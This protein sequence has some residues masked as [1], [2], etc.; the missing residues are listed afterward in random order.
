M[1]YHFFLPLHWH[2]GDVLE[3]R[4]E[5]T[6]KYVVLLTRLLKTYLDVATFDRKGNQYWEGSLV[7]D[8]ARIIDVKKLDG[9]GMSR[10]VRVL[11]DYL[12]VD[13]FALVLERFGR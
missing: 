13:Q 6:E 9:R 3:G 5:S 2:R 7:D 1:G 12:D 10:I 4:D 11:Y 8:L